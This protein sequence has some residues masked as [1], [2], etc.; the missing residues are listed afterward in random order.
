MQPTTTKSTRSFPLV[1][2]LGT[3]GPVLRLECEEDPTDAGSI[4][5]TLYIGDRAVMVAKY[6]CADPYYMTSVVVDVAQAAVAA[7]LTGRPAGLM[8]RQQQ[9]E[10]LREAAMMWSH[11]VEERAAMA[12]LRRMQQA[13]L[14]PAPAAGPGDQLQQA[15]AVL[16]G[17]AV[18]FA[19]SVIKG[20]GLSIVDGHAAFD[21][22]PVR[23]P[24]IIAPGP[25][26]FHGV[27]IGLP[28]A[29]VSPLPYGG[30]P[31]GVPRPT[32]CFGA[33]T[34]VLDGETFNFPC[35]LPAGHAGPHSNVVE[36]D[37]R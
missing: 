32:R 37:E 1:P 31:P 10:S 22:T 35:V 15:S 25:A 36:A 6:D 24:D 16:E 21:A 5:L 30:N 33:A 8:D 3:A 12:T 28:P 14:L 2:D 13:G 23:E 34:V 9:A 17:A 4:G 26:R 27:D 19:L 7:A 20:Q 29:P 11:V 18:I